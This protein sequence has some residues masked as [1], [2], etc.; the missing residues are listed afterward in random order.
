MIWKVL[1]SE[2]RPVLGHKWSK[3]E[4]VVQSWDDPNEVGKK[5][6]EI[7]GMQVVFTVISCISRPRV[8]GRIVA[9]RSVRNAI[10]IVCFCVR[11]ERLLK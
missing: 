10:F 5:V 6:V 1:N 11:I 2:E 3:L 7:S 8:Y 9:L 4:S